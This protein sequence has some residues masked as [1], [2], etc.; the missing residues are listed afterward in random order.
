[1][2]SYVA[3][4]PNHWSCVE[5]Q[6]LFELSGE[7]LHIRILHPHESLADDPNRGVAFIHYAHPEAALKAVNSLN[8]TIPIGSNKQIQVKIANNT[9]TN[10]PPPIVDNNENNVSVNSPHSLHTSSVHNSLIASPVLLS[11]S[12]SS[13]RSSSLQFPS[14]NYNSNNPSPSSFDLSSHHQTPPSNN[15]VVTGEF[16][17]YVAGFPIDWTKDELTKLFLPY[18]LSGK[19]GPIK[20]LL[21]ENK[22]S[23][24]VAFIRFQRYDEA[25]AAIT[26]LNNYCPNDGKGNNAAAT[27]N[28]KPLQVKFANKK[29]TNNNINNSIENIP[30]PSP[31]MNSIPTLNVPLNNSNPILNVSP[32]NSSSLL[33]P[34]LLSSSTNPLPVL[35]MNPNPNASMN[36]N[37]ANLALYNNNHGVHPNHP[38][39][40][41]LSSV[42]FPAFQPSPLNAFDLAA[43][44]TYY[45]NYNP[46][47]IAPLPIAPLLDPSL[48][49]LY[50][51]QAYNYQNHYALLQQQ[52]QIAQ[53][54]YQ[55]AAMAL[56]NEP[57]QY[58]NNPSTASTVN[59]AT[60]NDG[61]NPVA[62]PL[63]PTHASVFVCHFPDDFNESHLL[64]LFQEYGPIHSCRII[65]DSSSHSSKP[66]KV[67]AFVNF[68]NVLDAQNAIQNVNGLQLEGK[69]I[70]AQMKTHKNDSNKNMNLN[71]HNHHLNGH[72]DP[73]H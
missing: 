21:D 9:N 54:N 30:S 60:S 70:K 10:N 37:N 28:N 69:F 18:S 62:S 3:G 15:H 72:G 26:A 33:F 27:N 5:L 36:S 11:P 12:H 46:N 22:Q 65:R 40:N 8:G 51:Q 67:Y 41:P 2:F 32:S 6:P 71:L 1:L 57:S 43:Y 34:P 42:P 35:N 20:L 73:S 61:G 16:N 53:F 24:G 17:V 63:N 68:L 49:S 45:N 14:S 31:S 59:D 13:I 29:N 66:N 47:P 23:R 19:L 44:Q 56:N 39:P 52:Q 25:V 58:A 55:M 50:V 64:S 7:I 4:F 38:T 48:A